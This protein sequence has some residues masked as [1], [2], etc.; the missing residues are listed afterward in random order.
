[1]ARTI[2]RTHERY[3]LIFKQQA[4]RLSSHPNVRVKD[5]AEALNIHV[6]ML[7]RWRMEHNRGELVGN[8]RMEDIDK[9]SPKSRQRNTDPH[10]TTQAELAKAKKRIREL[11]KSLANREDEIDLLKKAHRFFEKNRD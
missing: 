7:Y 9:P 3:T 1:M 10:E 2:H 11:E 5:I 6:A 8:K 4:V